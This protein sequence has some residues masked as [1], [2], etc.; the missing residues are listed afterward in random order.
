M[1]SDRTQKG[2]LLKIRR[3]KGGIGGGGGV[4]GAKAVL[5]DGRCNTIK[6]KQ[7]RD[8]L[9]L[10]TGDLRSEKHQKSRY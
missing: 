5:E 9:L 10:K 7:T 4:W 2:L 1:R 8:E 3:K 6:N